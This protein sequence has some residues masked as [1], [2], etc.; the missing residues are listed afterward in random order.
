MQRRE[1][2]ALLGGAAVWPRSALAQQRERVRRIG[3]LVGAE[4][5]G[6]VQARF[7]V[8]REA[9]RELGLVDGRDV[10]IDI[11]YG[12]GDADIIR[13][14]VTELIALSPDIILASSG[15]VMGPLLQT[16]R[17]I[18]IVFVVVPDPVGSGFVNSL[19]RPG[20]NA[21]GFTQF[22]YSLSGKWVELLREFAP[23]VTRAAVV[24]NPSVPAGIGQFAIIQSMAPSRRVEVIPVSLRDRAEAERTIADIARTG[25]GGLIVTAAAALTNAYRDLIIGLAARHKLPAVYPN[26]QF[27]SRGGLMCYAADFNEQYRLAAGYIDRILKGEKPANLPVQ[28]PTKY[29]LV[30]N[31]KTAKALGIDVPSTLLAR[32]D[33]VIE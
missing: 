29:E 3:V 22:E 12:A 6:D 33:E 2:I 15:A 16:T 24:W 25:A 19:A 31:L 21:T 26:R 7:A 9:L 4:E 17:S 8:F 28:N 23:G 20:G 10:H 1:F 11:R 18:P 30:I 32:A 27:V 14:G 5:R 13:K